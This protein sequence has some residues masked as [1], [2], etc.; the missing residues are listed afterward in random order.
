MEEYIDDLLERRAADR[1]PF[2]DEPA[3]AEDDGV[4]M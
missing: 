3:P 1:E 2:G 4:D